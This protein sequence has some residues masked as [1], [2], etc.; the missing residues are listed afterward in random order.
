MG[1]VRGLSSRNT[2]SERADEYWGYDAHIRE[3]AQFAEVMIQA[4][5]DVRE[6]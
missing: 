1:A 3:H 4:R 6:A 2:D 5:Y